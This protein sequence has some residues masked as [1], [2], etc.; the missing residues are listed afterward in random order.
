MPKMLSVKVKD[1]LR[2]SSPPLYQNKVP[3]DDP[4]QL[5]LILLDLEIQGTNIDKVVDEFKR[6]KLKQKDMF[7]W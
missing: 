2:K 3:L 1:R 5:A 7:P 4:K 6:L